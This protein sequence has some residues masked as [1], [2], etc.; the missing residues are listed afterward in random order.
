MWHGFKLGIFVLLVVVFL[1]FR[2]GD[3]SSASPAPVV[4]T[5]SYQVDASEVSVGAA[6]VVF[7]VESGE[8]LLEK[9]A[10]SVLPIASV[11]KLF[12]AAA[13]IDED[14]SASTTISYQDVWA[15]EEFG[16][17]HAGEE[18]VLRE[19]L[20]PLLL[21][22]SNDAAAHF[23]R[24]TKGEVITTMNQL[25]SEAGLQ[26][27]VLADASG[28]SSQNVSTASDLARFLSYL[29]QNEPHVLDIT[30]LRQYVGPYTGWLNNSP[31]LSKDYAG[32]KHGYTEAAQ[33]T[34][35][36]LFNETISDAPRTI[37]YVVLGSQ[38]L[39]RDVALLRDFIHTNVRYQ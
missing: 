5:P 21:E 32:G 16:K 26:N 20:F 30:T 31:V 14:L 10:L 37:G 25:A 12:T 13:L 34:G 29:Y 17:L 27:T 8:V 36:V 35:A 11:T 39:A 18:Y 23:E 24:V 3:F 33:K 22:S 4:A 1:S 28:L 2:T 6:F 15:E 19:L 38:N 9:Q 7:D